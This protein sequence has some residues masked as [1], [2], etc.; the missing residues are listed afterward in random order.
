MDVDG[1]MT[2]GKIYMGNNGEVFKA[3]DIKDGYGI[4]E[5]LP[6]H[7]IKTAIITG[8]QSEIVQNRA[9]ELEI[10][11][12]LQQIKD[13]KKA[14]ITLVERAKCDLGEVAY[15]GD[16]IMDLEAMNLCGLVGAP[17]DAV[18]EIKRMA[19]FVCTKNGGQGAIREFIEWL[20]KG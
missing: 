4:H 14:I 7:G 1:T 9:L 16:D 6:M 15:I 10:D 12:V 20:I 5:I 19:D 17:R 3:F 11:F 8:R 18:D 13:K 2:D